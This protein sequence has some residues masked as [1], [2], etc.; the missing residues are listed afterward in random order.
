MLAPVYVNDY[1]S[2]GRI[3]R[4]VMRADAPF[5]TG[6]ESFSQFYSPSSQETADGTPAMIPLSNVV[7]SQWGMNTP[8]L[9]RY[10]GYS[11]ININ[12]SPAPGRSSGE[13]MAAMEAIV[14]EQL[15][16]GI[17]SDWTG[18]SYQE[19]IAGNTAT[20]LLVLSVLVVF[21]CLAALYESWSIPVSVLLV[22]PLGILG[23][24]VFT[25]L[26][27]LSNDIFFMIGLV[28]VI[29]LAA[30]NAILIVEFAVLERAAG[31]TLR[32][33]T[34]EAARL[35]FRPILMTS[36]AF[37][38]G[39]VPMAISTGAGANA[40]HAIGTGVIGGMLFA[41]FLGLLLIP[42]FFVAVRR[43]LGDKMDE[44]A[45]QKQLVQPQD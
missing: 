38:M 13:A 20:L 43:M 30:K 12:G 3:K 11:A 23:A 18:M 24:V 45:P 27:G 40:R 41:T 19:I 32:D 15:P 44:P 14:A 7:R 34:I 31:K 36:L 17:G 29:G 4:V 9:T 39:V 16:A 28:T 33:A 1:F 26:R 10:N 5:R 6:Q 35:R 42:V 21:L 2:N 25:M 22:V 37:I 8:S